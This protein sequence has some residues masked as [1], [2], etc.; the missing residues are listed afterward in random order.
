MPD[1]EIIRMFVK[2]SGLVERY[3]REQ[4]SEKVNK[5]L[6]DQEFY[7]KKWADFAKYNTRNNPYFGKSTRK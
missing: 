5:F 2:D 7:D 4:K 6:V 3:Q 1:T